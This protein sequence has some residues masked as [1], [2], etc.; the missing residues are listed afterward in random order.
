MRNGIIW[1]MTA[2][3]CFLPAQILAAETAEEEASPFSGTLV[4]AF[5]AVVAFLIL[6]VILWKLVWKRLLLGLKEREEHI[7][8]QINDAEDTSKEAKKVLEDY[9]SKLARA[10]DEGRK[11]VERHRDKAEQESREIIT[12]AR[13]KADAMRVKAEADIIKAQQQAQAELLDEAG[14]IVLKLGKDILGRSI[15]SRDTQ[16]LIDNAVDKLR[17]EGGGE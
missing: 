2:I 11:I 17:E 13:E 1:A 14:D 8:K 10:E 9:R 15:E 16:K 12:L 6:L 7:A 5:S 4:D 3:F